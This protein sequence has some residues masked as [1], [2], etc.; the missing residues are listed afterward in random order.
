[1]LKKI[2]F[3][4]ALQ[5]IITPQALPA[6][7]MTK[8]WEHGASAVTWTKT[9]YKPLLIGAGAT[10]VLLM[11]TS[12]LA[13]H[14]KKRSF[15]QQLLE[16]SRQPASLKKKIVGYT[17]NHEAFADILMTG[18]TPNYTAFTAAHSSGPIA[19]TGNRYVLEAFRKY[20]DS[21]PI[22]LD[23]AY[24]TRDGAHILPN[25][26][27]APDGALIQNSLVQDALTQLTQLIAKQPSE[28]PE[29]E[30]E[31]ESKER[32]AVAGEVQPAEVEPFCST[33]HA[34]AFF[35]KAFAKQTQDA[36]IQRK[37][38]QQ[39]GDIVL[40]RYSNGD[41]Q[42]FLHPTDLLTVNNLSADHVFQLYTLHNAVVSPPGAHRLTFQRNPC[43]VTPPIVLPRHVWNTVKLHQKNRFNDQ[44]LIF[45][46][47]PKLAFQQIFHVCYVSIGLYITWIILRFGWRSSMKIASAA[48]MSGQAALFATGQALGSWV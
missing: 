34:N 15:Q 47:R 9:N 48:N 36:L 1:M 32:A 6:A 12:A 44:N 17:G 16:A 2:Y 37:L 10:T 39:P 14:C 7:T 5:V 43:I 11:C 31:K 4:L 41:D 40:V 18:V 38:I 30:R 33:A 29:E 8:S 22:A 3:L 25:G 13:A 27:R 20:K 19:L 46:S 28:R 21:H 24:I 42:Y 26:D 23:L 35:D 45:I